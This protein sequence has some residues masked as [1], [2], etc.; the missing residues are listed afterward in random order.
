[1]TISEKDFKVVTFSFLL[2]KN[3][4]NIIL[5]IIF[6]ENKCKLFLIK[7]FKIAICL[8][9]K[10]KHK[11]KQQQ[12]LYHLKMLLTTSTAQIIQFFAMTHAL[13][14]SHEMCT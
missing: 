9:I 3:Y 2:R 12:K 4:N 13:Q 7:E 14:W 11:Q 8:A 6:R 1:M 10:K 5:I